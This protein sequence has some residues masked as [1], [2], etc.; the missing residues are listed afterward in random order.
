MENKQ[1][2]IKDKAKKY[3]CFNITKEELD[4]ILA[5]EEQIR[6]CGES[7]DEDYSKWAEVQIKNIRSFY[8]KVKIQ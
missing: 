8:S 6:S 2:K 3:K 5:G 1:N 4:A 7:A